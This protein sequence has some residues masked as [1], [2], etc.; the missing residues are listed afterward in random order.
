MNKNIKSLFKRILPFA[1]AISLVLAFPACTGDNGDNNNGD[2]G[3]SGNN[4]NDT[5][6][7]EH[8]HNFGEWYET[9]PTCTADGYKTRT[10]ECGETETVT[11]PA[12]EHTMS[13]GFCTVCGYPYSY[14]PDFTGVKIAGY[15]DKTVTSLVLKAEFDG[16]A[17]TAIGSSAFFGF[18]KLTGITLPDTVTAIDPYAFHGCSKLESITLPAVTTVID[19]GAFSG[20]TSLTTVNI[21]AGVTVIGD[22]AFGYCTALTT[23]NF[24]GTTKQWNDVAKKNNWDSNTGNYTVVCTD[25]SITK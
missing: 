23:I 4:G 14:S 13:G 18:E 6:V 9:A 16:S 17:V 3:N 10:C 21:P 15:A 12:T 1:A 20:C 5:P 2:T 7:I 25:G 8:T 19:N 22:Y 24:G 11:I